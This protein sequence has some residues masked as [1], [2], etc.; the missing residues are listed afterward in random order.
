MKAVVITD[1]EYQTPLFTQLHEQLITYLGASEIEEYAVGRDELACCTGCF[2]CWVKTP[3]ECVIRDD[4]RHINRAIMN[5]DAV[6]YL[7]PVVF[8]QFSANIKT[9]VDRG[10]PNMLPFFIVRPDGSTMHPARYEQYPGYVIIG[11]GDAVSDEDAR[12]FAD[13]TRKHRRG[14][15]CFV[16]QPSTGL[17]DR[18]AGVTLAK[19]GGLL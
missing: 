2:G 14:A 15:E 3:G 17:D 8:G 1:K 7:T 6:F 5:S 4:I 11:Y 10:L 18:L 19:T 12:L 9:V 13:I 16:Y